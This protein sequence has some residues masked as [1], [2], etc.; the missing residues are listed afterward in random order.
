MIAF[1]ATLLHPGI[2]PGVAAGLYVATYLSFVHLL[3]YPR[4]W[5]APSVLTSLITG[6]LALLTVLVVSL[7]PDGIDV[8]ALVAL[9]FA[10]VVLFYMM[11]APAIAFRPASKLIEFMAKHGDYAGLY[12]S[13]LALFASFA[14]PNVNLHAVLVVACGIEISWFLRL[15]WADRTRQL[16]PLSDIDLAVLKSQAKG[17]LEVFQQRHGIRELI[18][19]PGK[20][21][22]KGC[23]K[24]TSPCPFNLYVNRLGLNTAPCCRQHM[25]DLSYHIAACLDQL[26]AIYWLEG[27]SLLGA[28]R[29]NG[30]LLDWEDDVD[31]SVLLDEEMSWDRLAAGLAEHGAR[32]GFYVDIFKQKGFISISFDHP[33]PWPFRWERN[34][35]RGEIR[36]DIAIYRRTTSYGKKV[37]ERRSQKG[38]IPTTE[39]GG[40]GV[41][42]EMVLPT[43]TLDFVGGK[44]SSPNQPE[45]YLQLM[46]GDFQ[47]IE[48]TYVDAEAAKTRQE[49]DAD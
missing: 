47:K 48:Y 14:I 31:I 5:R 36:A 29:E 24:K 49:I 20:V 19:S 15:R 43:S 13:I 12:F 21:S 42:Q 30:A 7:R 40:Y 28:V 4:N 33:K 46:Y 26:G 11:A 8:F 17:D 6:A 2:V 23:G 10:F 35:L 3:K 22:W 41:P 1:D 9:S 44:F 16:Y 39:N 27:G 32:E 38:N 25:K 45:S 37:L 34:R 18:L